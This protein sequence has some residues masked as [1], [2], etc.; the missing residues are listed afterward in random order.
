M[1]NANKHYCKR[2]EV[3]CECEALE[4]KYFNPRV[5]YWSVVKKES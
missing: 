2:Q 3:Y 4:H 1:S 5:S